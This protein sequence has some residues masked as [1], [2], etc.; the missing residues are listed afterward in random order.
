MAYND[1]I[2]IEQATYVRGDYGEVFKSWSEYKTVWAEVED[3]GGVVDYDADKPVLVVTKTFK[4]RK[5]DAPA[6]SMYPKM[7]LKY[8]GDYYHITGLD[9]EGNQRLFLTL[10]AESMSDDAT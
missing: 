8:D 6:P 5:A 3:L 1:K 10:T 2:E 7:R 9:K 4:M